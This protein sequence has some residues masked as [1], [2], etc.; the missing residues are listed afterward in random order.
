MNKIS[1][2]NDSYLG[3]REIAFKTAIAERTLSNGQNIPC[4]SCGN[5]YLIEAS[6]L[7][8]VG[9]LSPEEMLFALKHTTE[10]LLGGLDKIS[11]E[12][13]KKENEDQAF[14]KGLGVKW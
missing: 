14:M 6:T 5:L 7:K 1:C 4:L 10:Y 11:E 9:K 3:I 8:Q 2:C 13:E 12:K